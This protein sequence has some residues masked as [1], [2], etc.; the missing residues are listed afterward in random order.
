MD[1]IKIFI[2]KIWHRDEYRIGVSFRANNQL[3][4]NIQSLGAAWS[5]TFN[6]W[7]LPYNKEVF[8]AFKK[9][10]PIFEIVSD[11]SGQ[12]GESLK[13]EPDL[14]NNHDHAPIVY[15]NK[16]EVTE[17][18][19]LDR[20][21]ISTNTLVEHKNENSAKRIIGLELYSDVGK[22]W[23]LKMPYQE[24]YVRA[25]LKVK[26][27]YWNKTYQAYMVFRHITVKN[28]V[29]ALLGITGFLPTNY[30][31][32]EAGE[33][34]TT[35][36]IWVD[37]HPDQ[38]KLILV[39]TPP[40]AV[41]IQII[42]RWQGAR[43]S[44]VEN[45]YELPATP[46]VMENI[47]RLAEQTGM[48]VISHLS[49]LYLNRRYAP[50]IKS[51]KFENTIQLLQQQ[52]PKQIE[53]YI[54]AMMDYLMALN[55]SDKTLNLYTMNM[56]YFLRQN[57]YCNPDDMSE[58]EVIRHLGKMMRQGLSPSAAHNLINALK[59]YYKNVLKREDYEIDIPR[60]KKE[61]K[62][63]AVLTLAECASIFSV[64]DNPKHKL[65][66]LLGY[67]AGLRLGEIIT[68]QWT[69]I[70]FAEFK[71]HIK[72]GKGRKDRYVML[73]HTIVNYMEQYRAMYPVSKWVFEGQ[74]KGESYSAKSVQLVMQK[75]IR[76]SGLEKRAT[77]HTLRHSFATH[78]LES[79]TDIRYIQQLLGHSSI[80]TTAI[81]THLTSVA[82]K[83]ITSPLDQMMNT[84][85]IFRKRLK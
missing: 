23:V 46:Q 58:A 48:K 24:K 32:S 76:L 43:Y 77:V 4:Q 34:K 85:E 63:P 54:N 33:L 25:L 69:D 74:Y 38:K 3:N 56:I 12:T 41:L 36:E 1:P 50:S 68:L 53:T 51:I 61:H 60:P 72:G 47:V 62:L 40:F 59:F 80:K 11:E 16:S 22:Y 10:F 81:Y 15:A 28:K 2:K 84:E 55:Y 17:K 49:E 82:V 52:T 70:L 21:D 18:P 13:K 78:L 14:Q 9:L 26:G 73:P 83:K 37:K 39:R 44:K 67:G 30:Y 6:C 31:K 75:A 35:G 66:L 7:Y 19:A 71:I 8:V 42:K 27:V 64:I 79:G 29:E 57:N 5:K 20:N 45:A 65:L